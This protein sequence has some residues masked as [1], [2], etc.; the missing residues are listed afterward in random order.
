MTAPLRKDSLALTLAK[1][2]SSEVSVFG[3]TPATV[4]QIRQS[5]HK[6]SVA[7]PQMSQD[8]FNLLVERIAKTNMSSQRLEYAVNKV[9]DTFTYKQLTIADIL[10][11]DVRCRVL[12][13]AE[14]CNEAARRNVS[15]DAY[16]PV[17]IGGLDKPGWVS[18][19]DKAR[20]N[21]P[22]EL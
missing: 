9:L 5:V 20:Y 1:N 8:F 10:S 13:Y 15:T 7:F 3:S 2:G 6:L 21:I 4:M 14:M 19:V 17:R 16:A 11:L 18:K 12:S 22:D